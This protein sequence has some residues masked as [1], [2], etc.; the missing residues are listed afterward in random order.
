M[1]GPINT[2][3]K[4]GFRRK[5]YFVKVDIKSCFDSI[6]PKKVLKIV[7]GLLTEDMYRLAHHAKIIPSGGSVVKKFQQ[8]V[9][10]ENEIDEFGNY[11]QQARQKGA[12]YV[13]KSYIR[14]ISRSD[15][16]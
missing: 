9:I 2:F 13:D 3:K 16:L 12:V 10:G 5:R 7:T 1:Y 4:K 14:C 8:R 11:V 6:P 15:I